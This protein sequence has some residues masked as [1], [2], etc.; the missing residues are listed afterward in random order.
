MDAKSL[1]PEWRRGGHVFMVLVAV[2]CGVAGAA[3][4]V[5]FRFLIRLFQGLFWEGSA[6]VGQVLEAGLLAEP[7]DPLAVASA[8]PWWLCVLIP[9]A[10]GLVVGPLVW[11]F[12][13][14]AKGHGVPE[15]MEAVALRGGVMRKRTAAVKI[16]A[17][18]ISIGSGGSVGREGPI[19]QIGSVMGSAIGQWLRVP[20]RQLR[21]IVG[22]GAAAGVSATFNAPI[23]GAIFAVEVIVGDFAVTQFS[24]IVIS[25]VVATVISRFFLGNHPAFE[26]PD[27]ELVA[28][29]ELVAYVGVGLVAGLVGLAFM[30]TLYFSEDTF[31]RLPM[32]EWLKASVGGALVGTIGIVVPNVFGV[33]Y[34]TITEALSG[35]LPFLALGIFLV[36]KILATSITIGSGGSGGVFAPSL[37]L[38]ATT[39]GLVGT[40]VHQWFPETTATSGAYALVTMGA[41][42]AA[43]SHAP[44]T[45]ILIIFEMTQSITILPPL[46]A[47]CV[48]STLVS[49]FIQRESIYT[50]KLVRRGIDI[51]TQ[52]DPNL[53]K[54][55]RVG[56]IVDRSPEVLPPSARFTTV[57]DLIVESDHTEFFV[58]NEA[59]EYLGAI[60]LAEL[61]RVLHEQEDLRSVVVAGDLLEAGRPTVAEDDDLDVVMRIFGQ[62]EVEEIAVVDRENRRRLLGSVHKRDVLAAYNQEVMRRDLAGGISSTVGAVDRVHEVPLGGD[63]VIRD[64]PAPHT[65]VGRSLAELDLRGRTGALVLLI[66]NPKGGGQPIRVP[67][68]ADRIGSGD[69]LIVAGSRESLER[70]ESI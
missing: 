33:G 58:V 11:F 5:L 4:A 10:G 34:S 63:Y 70:L 32:P 60:Y 2:A 49:S 67:T 20:P 57:I 24:P 8:L 64:V 40:L 23:A 59:G 62:E 56:E 6:G 38:G 44:I 13:R 61:R 17:S 43:T 1:T 26:V 25:A 41:V 42:V 51:R 22:C 68:P 27:Y 31:D 54:A 28:P 9:A 66:R 65:F 55:M 48:V 19:V 15:V 39:G 3:G 37:F 46:M 30:K 21:T 52:D 12:A 45:A 69:V 50:M 7:H 18:A 36:A 47:A 29:V 16:L 35:N 14:E 53:L